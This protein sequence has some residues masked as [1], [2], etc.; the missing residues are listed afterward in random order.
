MRTF[1]C[2][3]KTALLA[4]CL[5]DNCAGRKLHILKLLCLKY[6]IVTVG[7]C[8]FVVFMSLW[9][10]KQTSIGIHFLQR[11]TTPDF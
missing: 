1:D 11:V 10:E 5:M 8:D 3:D 6:T 7:T 9:L 2:I 4:V